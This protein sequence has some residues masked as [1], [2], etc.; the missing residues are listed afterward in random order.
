[1]PV[2]RLLSGSPSYRLEGNTDFHQRPSA[3]P[4]PT[5]EHEHA[6]CARCCAPPKEKGTRCGAAAR[7]VRVDERPILLREDARRLTA[8]P[9]QLVEPDIQLQ[10]TDLSGLTKQKSTKLTACLA[11]SNGIWPVWWGAQYT[12]KPKKSDCLL[13]LNWCFQV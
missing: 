13:L 5:C 3:K 2:A 7:T 9:V 10:E 4:A 8:A 11:G 1:M 12:K 6:F